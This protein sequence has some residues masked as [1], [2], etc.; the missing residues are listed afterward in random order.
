MV[1]LSF[2]C[3]TLNNFT[4]YPH[5]VFV[6]SRDVRKNT[7]LNHWFLL[8]RREVFTGRCGLNL[9]IQSVRGENVNIVGGHSIGHSK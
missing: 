2:I 6:F 3:L 5:R 9:Y 4:L 7:A 1:T 8:L